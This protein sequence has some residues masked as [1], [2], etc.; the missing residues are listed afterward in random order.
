MRFG[1]KLGFLKPSIGSRSVLLQMIIDKSSS[2]KSDSI[3]K[4]TNIIPIDRTFRPPDNHDVQFLQFHWL[5]RCCSLSIRVLVS[6]F[7]FFILIYKKIFFRKYAG[8]FLANI[9]RWRKQVSQESQ[10][11]RQKI[12]EL[13]SENTIFKWNVKYQAS[14]R[15]SGRTHKRHIRARTSCLCNIFTKCI[16]ILWIKYIQH[17]IFESL[18]R[19]IDTEIILNDS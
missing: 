3:S 6:I 17:T 7:H 9:S 12:V 18:S 5:I 2:R 1:L 13:I 15:F 16:K 4:E 14:S 10:L 19:C 8:D 11:K